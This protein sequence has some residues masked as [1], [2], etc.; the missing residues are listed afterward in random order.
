MTKASE[1]LDELL[2][3]YQI[4]KTKAQ[5][6]SICQFVLKT[7][8]WEVVYESQD[9]FSLQ[10]CQRI[11]AEDIL[12]SI[13]LKTFRWVLE[14]KYR[15]SKHLLNKANFQIKILR[16]NE[17]MQWQTSIYASDF[18][19]N[20]LDWQY[21]MQNQPDAV[22]S[23]Y[24][25]ELLNKSSEYLLGKDGEIFRLFSIG[26]SFK[27]IAYRS[28]EKIDKVKQNI[29]SSREKFKIIYRWEPKPRNLSD[30]S[31]Q[32]I[33]LRKKG[34]AMKQIAARLNISY[35]KVRNTL[36]KGELS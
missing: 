20:Y 16:C 6:H 4:N 24:S 9:F 23:K 13:Y 19:E 15:S 5:I 26:Y 11:N 34:M 8:R 2:S 22:G 17:I 32:I 29:A 36:S 10:I 12:N 28:G 21:Y 35:K 14:N 33:L 18:T 3:D 31:D 30:M 25:E 7:I 27:Q 1:K